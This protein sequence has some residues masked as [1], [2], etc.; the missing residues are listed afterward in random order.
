[1]YF[2]QSKTLI[3]IYNMLIYNGYVGVYSSLFQNTMVGIRQEIF[4]FLRII[5]Q[6]V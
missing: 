3:K 6:R 5:N 2:R 1:M 4:S